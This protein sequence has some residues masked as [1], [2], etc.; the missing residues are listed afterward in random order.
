AGGV[1]F[2]DGND[3]LVRQTGYKGHAAS[4]IS[5]VVR[6]CAV[7]LYRSQP[8]KALKVAAE[9]LL[10]IYECQPD[11]FAKPCLASRV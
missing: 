1:L 7:E 9:K 2:A 3:D 11:D 4:P 6:N 8:V 10:D 5:R